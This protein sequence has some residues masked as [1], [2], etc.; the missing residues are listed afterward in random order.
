MISD[1]NDAFGRS[2]CSSSCIERTSLQSDGI[3]CKNVEASQATLS[4][5]PSTG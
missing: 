3:H 5:K 1:G 4:V 2:E